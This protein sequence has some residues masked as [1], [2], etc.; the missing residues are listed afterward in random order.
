MWYPSFWLCILVRSRY[1]C[2]TGQILLSE[3]RPSPALGDM[4]VLVE[5]IERIRAQAKVRVKSLLEKGQHFTD[6]VWSLRGRVK[7]TERDSE[8][9]RQ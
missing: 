1:G 6:R 5:S 8:K 2:K 9:Q 4:W 3:G 7:E